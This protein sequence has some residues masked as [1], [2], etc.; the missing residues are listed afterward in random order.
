MSKYKLLALDLDGTLT[1]GRKEISE[2]NKRYLEMAQRTGVK[3]VLASGRPVLGI[4]PDAEALNL[5]GR[6]GYILAYNGGHMIDCGTGKDLFRKTIPMELYHEICAVH[7]KFD[8]YPLTY[9]HKG[10]ICEN[11]ESEY[12]KREGYN[13]RI[14]VIK[15][16]SL[17]EEI[18]EPVVKFMVV[19][20]HEELKRAREYLLKIYEGVLNIFFSEP[21]FL[22]ITPPGIE[23]GAALEQ[24]CNIL[25]IGKEDVMACGDGLN[26]IPM[27]Q[28]AGL[29]VAMGNAC[30]EIK[31]CADYITASNEEDGVAKA[32]RKFLLQE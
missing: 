15:V 6:G 13:N 22:E 4:C 26:D 10:V 8:A 16:A 28:F 24:L 21:Y 12:V 14:P 17:E 32:V 3:I 5:Y 20:V 30:D 29:S 19:G 18:R 1:N 2:E 31:A 27:L 23:K 7:K 25:S 9:N 11:T